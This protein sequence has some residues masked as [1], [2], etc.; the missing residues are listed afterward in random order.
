[1]VCES[2]VCINQPSMLQASSG[3]YT[4]T[5]TTAPH[6]QTS[7]VTDHN[8]ADQYGASCERSCAAHCLHRKVRHCTSA[9]VSL[10]SLYPHFHHY[11]LS[12]LS[13]IDTFLIPSLSSLHSS[14]PVS[15]L[16]S[17]KPSVLLLHSLHRHIQNYIP[18]PCFI[19]TSFPLSV[20]SLHSFR[21]HFHHYIPSTLFH[22][23]IPSTLS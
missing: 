12:T 13:L 2:K 14:H 18:S 9:V 20:S 17:R 10:H 6:F 22:Y 5:T 21:P 16:H 1:M 4:T 15:S 8:A 19:I 23:Y 3:P 7:H 11:I